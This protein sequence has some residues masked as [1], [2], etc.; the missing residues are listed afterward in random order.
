MIYLKVQYY[1][2]LF[3]VTKLFVKE[4]AKYGNKVVQLFRDPQFI[5]TLPHNQ[6]IYFERLKQRIINA[7]NI[8]KIDYNT[9]FDYLFKFLSWA[10]PNFTELPTES[11]EEV[12][13]FLKFVFH[14]G[15][16]PESMDQPPE[17]KEQSDDDSYNDLVALY[18]DVNAEIFPVDE[19]GHRIYFADDPEA[20]AFWQ[21]HGIEQWRYD[22]D[23]SSADSNS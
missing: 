14:D 5:F 9:Y 4:F 2:D 7:T 15:Q 23:I 11:I 8:P 16:L 10:D 6:Q 13:S 12:E 18:D 17:S 21:E 19:E 22:E 3:D 20:Y 1:Q